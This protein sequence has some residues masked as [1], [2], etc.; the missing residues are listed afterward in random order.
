MDGRRWAVAAVVEQL[1]GMMQELLALGEYD[2]A[3][4]TGRRSGCGR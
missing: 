2:A 3:K 4:R 1:R